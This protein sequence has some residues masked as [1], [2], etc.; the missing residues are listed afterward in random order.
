MRN[1]SPHV[2]GRNQT[3]C[4]DLGKPFLESGFKTDTN[5]LT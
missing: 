3:I 1:M 5:E 4:A 2:F